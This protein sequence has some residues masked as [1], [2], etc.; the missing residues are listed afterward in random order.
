MKC[1]VLI[2]NLFLPASEFK[3]DPLPN[4]ETLISRGERTS[5]ESK[6][7]EEWICDA[8][9]VA[10]QQDWPVA[11]LHGI[12]PGYWLRADPAHLQLRRDWLALLQADIAQEEADSLVDSL[13]R[14]FEADGFRFYIERP[15]VWLLRL[16]DAIDLVTVPLSQAI[17][18][19]VDDCLPKGKDA[20]RMTAVMNEIQMLF[21][22]HPVNSTRDVPINSVWFWG[23][24]ILPEV[25]PSG[26]ASVSSSNALASAIANRA[27]I[28]CIPVP[29]NASG[30]LGSLSEG[31][32]L[33]ILED[34]MLPARYGDGNEWDK[35]LRRLETCWFGPLIDAV[36][37]GLELAIIDNEIG[38]RFDTKKHDLWKFWKRSR[39]V[40]DCLK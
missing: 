14:H 16:H 22:D 29:E 9:D 23:G 31:E 19:N 1:H 26:Y 11:A 38:V 2:P 35:R 3:I 28:P 20:M 32:H 17:G 30:W 37:N 36:K 12:E 4:V 33:V 13:N 7:F 6:G 10:K 21:H 15:D 39:P 27:A 8:F 34:L 25:K 5:F 24:G 40:L 18:R